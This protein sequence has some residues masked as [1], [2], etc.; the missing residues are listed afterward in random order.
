MHYDYV[1]CIDD[2]S[3]IYLNATLSFLLFQ[4]FYLFLLGHINGT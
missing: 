1:I 2:S 4:L 3:E